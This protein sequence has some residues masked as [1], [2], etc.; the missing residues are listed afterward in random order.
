LA[1]RNEFRLA[2]SQ[3]PFVLHG[4]IAM[5]PIVLLLVL[6]LPHQVG[7]TQYA[8]E[9]N[10]SMVVVWG[11]QNHTREADC[12]ASARITSTDSTLTIEVDVTDDNLVFNGDSL[13][14]D[15]VEVWFSPSTSYPADGPPYD[16]TS[17]IWDGK[18]NLYLYKE[19]ADLKAF[20][21]EIRSPL[22][23][24]SNYSWESLPY[25]SLDPTN[26]E[27]SWL[28]YEIDRYLSDVRHSK[29]SVEKIFYGITHFGIFPEN[30]RVVLYD[31]DNYSVLEKLTGL[32]IPDLTRF[33]VVQSS[34]KSDGYIL[35]MTFGPEAIGF[36]GR[37]GIMQ[38]RYMVDVVDVDESG[39]QQ[40]ILSTS[41]HK[42]WGDP[43]T[44][45]QLDP[46]PQIR[47]LLSPDF[48]EAGDPRSCHYENN[49]L[50]V[51][52][53]PPDFLYTQAGWIPVERTVDE[54]YAYDQ[55]FGFS[56]DNIV[57]LSYHRAPFRYR[58][59][60]RGKDTL[61]F[62]NASMGEHLFVGRRLVC[63]TSDTLATFLLS[64]SSVA[65]LLSTFE[66][67]GSFTRS[68]LSSLRLAAGSSE[69]VLAELL[70]G[71]ELY[72]TDSLRFE[73]KQWDRDR[74]RWDEMYDDKNFD[75]SHVYRWE[76]FGRSIVIDLGN[77]IRL[78]LSWD[79]QGSNVEYSRL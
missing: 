46:Y 50:P 57:K 59:E 66:S 19:M 32:Q 65:V 63:N 38:L 36:S 11:Q 8:R 56:L 58:V 54:F 23:S 10:D 60:Q 45:K 41:A 31:R 16:P 39:K 67:S 14:S 34:R 52:Y 74:M 53:L 18:S 61:E 70:N 51:N 43:S 49:L 64:D 1:K 27:D 62:L 47:V 4:E 69:R 25:D 73:E 33:V 5:K 48:R 77:G 20:R 13:H 78:R 37:N 44:F 3:L 79:G 30:G 40:T 24:A 21:S 35:M 15:H 12:S 75:W 71:S 29:L 9:R 76:R 55:P 7:W 28:R 26:D 17:Y 6:T 68:F 42:R 2:G 72:C 22:I